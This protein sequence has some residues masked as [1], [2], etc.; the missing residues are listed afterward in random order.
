MGDQERQCT[1]NAIY[2]KGDSDNARKC[3][4]APFALR[5]PVQAWPTFW[6]LV[7]LSTRVLLRNEEAVGCIETFKLN[8]KVAVDKVHWDIFQ[9]QINPL[10]G[11]QKGVGGCNSRPLFCNPRSCLGTQGVFIKKRLVVAACSMHLRL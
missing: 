10:L 8:N 5:I 11:R 6:N 1:D 9:S 3:T 7:F 2:G 4:A